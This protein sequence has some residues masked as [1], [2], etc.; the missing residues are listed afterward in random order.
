MPEEKKKKSWK[1]KAA[2][3][4]AAV[5]IL[6]TQIGNVLDNDPNTV[7]DMAAVATALGVFGISW[8]ARDKDVSSKASGVE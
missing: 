7:L 2:G 3:M 1:A 5:G 8:F 6:A 4:V